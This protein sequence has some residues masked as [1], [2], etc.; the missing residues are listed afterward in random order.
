ML[1]D[2]RKP[3]VHNKSQ[4]ANNNVLFEVYEENYTIL[5]ITVEVYHPK[6]I[7]T[8]KFFIVECSDIKW[9]FKVAWL[10][11]VSAKAKDT[12]K[13]LTTMLTF[14]KIPR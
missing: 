1:Q 4:E 2:M 13:G 7:C 3:L 10:C 12:G 6:T 14:H 5:G 9:F 8:Y 11:W